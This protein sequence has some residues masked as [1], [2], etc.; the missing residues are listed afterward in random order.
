MRSLPYLLLLLVGIVSCMSDDDYTLSANDKLYFSTDSVNFDTIISGE[1]TKTYSFVVYNNANKAIRISSVSLQ[2]GNSSPFKAN[3]DG[4]ALT[5]GI[6]TDFEIAK[7]D[8]MIVYLMANVPAT[9]LDT[10]VSYNDRLNFLTESGVSQSV[11]LTASGQDVINL[12]N[13]HIQSDETFDASRPYRVRDSLVVEKGATLTLT[14]GTTLMFHSNAQLIVH[15]RLCIDGTVNNPVI[16]RGDRLDHMFKNQPYDRTPGLWGGIHFTKESYNNHINYA[17]IHSGTYGIK[18]D[19]CDTSTPTLK[20]ENSVIHTVSNHGLDV[21]MGQ[22]F[23][24]NSQI[25][26]AGGDCVHVRGGNLQFI[27]CTIGR[28][29]VFSGG[30]GHALDFANYEEEVRLP[31]QR[32]D[33]KNCIITGYNDDEIMGDKNANAEEDAFNYS[34]NYSLLNTP[35]PKEDSEEINNFIQCI[36]D[37]KDDT[38]KDGEEE[39]VRDKN[40]RPEFNTSH[41]LFEFELNSKSKAIGTANTNITQEY[42]PYDRY[43]RTRFS[44]PDMGCYQHQKQE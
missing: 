37:Q 9:G 19:S 2:N 39:I 31:L 12:T 14:V 26:N 34:F 42:Y 32:L 44:A 18:I 7:K 35:E 24:G 36:W 16:L 33:F 27:H 11:Q 38:I 3:V 40:F 13:T 23:V 6:T 4:V 22:V 30:Y 21:R 28:F 8:S 41:L 25:T 29:Y 5:E 20:L 17:D 15:G 1:P 43:G 10:P